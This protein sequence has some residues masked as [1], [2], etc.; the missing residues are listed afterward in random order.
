LNDFVIALD[1]G[2]GFSGGFSGYCGVE[3]R[4]GIVLLSLGISGERDPGVTSA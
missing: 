2:F 4:F 1:C 3:E